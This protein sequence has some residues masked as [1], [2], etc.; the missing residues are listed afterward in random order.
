MVGREIIK[1]FMPVSDQPLSQGSH[2]PLPWEVHAS[3]VFL[4]K[5]KKAFVYLWLR[6]IFV[7]ASE[8]SL[9]VNERGLL[10]GCGAWAS[11]F[12]GFSPVL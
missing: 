1:D 11:H 6:W 2:A 7:A 9:A 10:S 5:K 12:G 4:K 3:F 8:V